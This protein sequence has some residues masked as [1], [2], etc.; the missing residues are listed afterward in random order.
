MS[1]LTATSALVRFILR[2]DRVRIAVWIIAI[3]ALMLTTVASV[4]GLYP[5]QASLDRAAAAAEDNPAVLALNGPPYGLR[6]LGGRVAFESGSFG[7]V[8]VGLMSV[9]MIGRNTRAEEESGR[10]ELVRA[11]VV[12]RYATMTAALIVVVLMNVAVGVVVALG[13]IGLPALGSI[14]FGAEFTV[15]GLVFAGIALV[16]AQVT[17]NTRVVYG[18]GGALLGFAFALRA[19]GDSTDGTLSWL[20]PSAGCRRA[21]RTPASACGRSCSRS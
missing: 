15:L 13:L 20:S 12:G 3:G 19:V 1:E 16:A 2:R 5:T 9:L 21:A 6:T 10:I 18:T 17:E 7:L 8:L 4:K 14:V 11:A